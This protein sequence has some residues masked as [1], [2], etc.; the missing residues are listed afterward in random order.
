[1]SH[2]CCKGGLS[3]CVGV[4]ECGLF[5]PW[6]LHT[7]LEFVLDWWTRDHLTEG[8]TSHCHAV[9]DHTMSFHIIS[10]YQCYCFIYT[11][12]MIISMLVYEIVLI[13][14]SSAVTVSVRVV[15]VL[16][17]S[18]EGVE[19]SCSLIHYIMS[20]VMLVGISEVSCGL[21]RTL[22]EWVKEIYANRMDRWAGGAIGGLMS[23]FV[24][25]VWYARV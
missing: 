6:R 8:S 24:V 19:Q 2:V 5:V 10:H 4:G 23:S 17:W 11:M 9:S 3:M 15:I 20:Q 13:F 22:E 18:W 1:M 21:D 16:V 14:V 12:I 25:C 7:A